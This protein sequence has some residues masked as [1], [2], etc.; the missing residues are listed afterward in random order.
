M[1]H[2]LVLYIALL[3][4]VVH[5]PFVQHFEVG[6]LF[7]WD[8]THWQGS[9]GRNAIVAQ[10]HHQ[11]SQNFISRTNALMSL[12]PV[13]RPQNLLHRSLK[14]Q[15]VNY[16]WLE[17]RLNP[18]VG[19]LNIRTCSHSL[20][21]FACTTLCTPTKAVNHNMRFL[22][23][24]FKCCSHLAWGCRNLSCRASSSWS[25]CCQG[26][27]TSGRSSTWRWPPP[28]R[29][30]TDNHSHRRRNDS[31][32][33]LRPSGAGRSE[34]LGSCCSGLQPVGQG[35][36]LHN[37]SQQKTHR[38]DLDHPSLDHKGGIPVLLAFLNLLC[39]YRG[40]KWNDLLWS[41]TK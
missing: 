35:S 21:S 14:K 41:L 3:L 19:L 16:G 4:W 18:I 33:R 30:W 22:C 13:G 7:F 39:E 5:L 31:H 23:S 20:L 15:D 10:Y 9:L 1:C 36:A 32:Q 27:K 26:T 17:G 12:I 28:R 34:S 11:I 40:H 2:A 6:N 38:F 8:K 29:G 37:N 24:T 25:C